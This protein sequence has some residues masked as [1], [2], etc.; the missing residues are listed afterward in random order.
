V[1]F[2]DHLVIVRGGGDLGTGV[3]ARLHRSGFPVIVTELDRPLTVRRTVA[4]S[5]AVLDGDITVEGVYATRVDDLD[6]AVRYAHEGIVPVV[7]STTLPDITRSVVVDAR[8]AKRNI[9]TS[10][11]D[12]R[13][14]VALG[15]GF[16][17]GHDCH[18]VVE[19]ARGHHLGRVLWEGSAEPNTG[20]PGVVG[21]RSADRVLRSPLQGVVQWRVNIGD[22][23]QAGEE[24]GTVSSFVVRAPFAGVVRGLIAGGMSVPIGIKIGDIDPR[25]D[26]P[27]N[28]ISD[29]ALAIG[30]GVLE[31]V[32]TWI[33]AIS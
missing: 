17:A 23:V 6:R 10:L 14:V 32:L 5:S 1:L 33:S 25:L 4:V 27:C 18:A 11:G 31:A 29:K 22:T 26:T 30:G 3:V 13:F 19:T 2:Q 20:V 24:L 16:T 8:I 15:P 7:I 12:A 21:G 9:D 28:E